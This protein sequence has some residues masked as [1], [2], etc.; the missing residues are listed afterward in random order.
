MKSGIT[1]YICSFLPFK[2]ICFVFF[3]CIPTATVINY[4]LS[5]V[6]ILAIIN[7]F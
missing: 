1:R 3:C 2:F 7:I 4:I 5:P 6:D